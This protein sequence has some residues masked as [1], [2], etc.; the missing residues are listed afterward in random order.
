MHPR[1]S[2]EHAL[3]TVHARDLGEFGHALQTG[4][5]GYSVALFAQ[6]CDCASF[7]MSYLLEEK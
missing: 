1:E 4:Q 2:D 6:K 5:Y 7:K 3:S